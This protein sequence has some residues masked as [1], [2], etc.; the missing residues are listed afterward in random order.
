MGIGWY[1]LGP[2]AFTDTSD[3]WLS[4]RWPRVMVNMA[5]IFT[6]ILV[7]GIA[8]L[9]IGVIVNPYVNAFLWL[10]ALY[11]YINAFRMLSPL[12]EWDGY[13]ILMDL[14]DRPRLRQSAVVWL[15]K[16]FP[17]SLR[18]PSLFKKHIPEIFYWICCIVFLILLTVIILLIEKFVFKIMGI[19]PANIFISLSLPLLVVLISCL[20]VLADLRKQ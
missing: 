7:A 2:I 3:M 19:Q 18:K 8:A 13:Y 1:W 11:T 17:K 20:G 14:L 15:V 10:F 12:Q 6:D 4:T 16:V 9:L 5:G